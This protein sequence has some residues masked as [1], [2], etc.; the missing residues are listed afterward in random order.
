MHFEVFFL[1]FKIQTWILMKCI[2]V[3]SYYFSFLTGNGG[4][5]INISCISEH[6]IKC[7]IIKTI[8]S[9]AAS[10]LTS[11]KVKLSSVSPFR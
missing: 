9:G 6:K 1:G 10:R 5:N 2:V 3:K 8:L 4:Q 7:I 11:E